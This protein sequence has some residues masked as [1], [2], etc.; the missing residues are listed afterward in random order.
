MLAR[1]K[2]HE[3]TLNIQISGN[4]S[5]SD[6][7]IVTAIGQ[8]DLIISSGQYV[9]IPSRHRPVHSMLQHITTELAAAT[10]S[11]LSLGSERQAH[12]RVV[13]TLAIHVSF[14]L[15]FSPYCCIICSALRSDFILLV[16]PTT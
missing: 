5:Y 3:A 6:C 13:Q 14:G 8:L 10:A 9:I 15:D 1:I 7:K 2:E 16:V 11:D 12:R 4:R